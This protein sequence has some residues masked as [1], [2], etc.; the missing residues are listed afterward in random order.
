MTER[1]AG[2]FS[3]PDGINSNAL[4]IKTLGIL[5][6][7]VLIQVNQ[8]VFSRITEVNSENY[9]P[10]DVVLPGFTLL[11]IRNR[12]KVDRQ[13]KK[14]T[15]F[16][17]APIL[18]LDPMG[19]KYRN[20][21]PCLC[22][23][24]ENID[25]FFTEKRVTSQGPTTSAGRFVPDTYPRQVSLIGDV[26]VK[27]TRNGYVPAIHAKMQNGQIVFFYVE[28]ES[29]WRP[30]ESLREKHGTL[31]RVS[32]KIYRESADR[33]AKYVVEPAEGGFNG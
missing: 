6:A 26:F 31:D 2:E 33:K 1:V 28:A 3:F 9:S 4:E 24:R 20:G 7:W 30:L 15:A 27:L 12:W 10:F 19:L 17:R 32:L 8:S 29:I 11:D 18:S 21:I 14:V 25:G 23:N 22:L 5:G 13:E 16:R